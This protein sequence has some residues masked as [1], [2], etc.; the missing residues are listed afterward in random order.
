MSP[1]STPWADRIELPDP[2]PTTPV[3]PTPRSRGEHSRVPRLRLVPATAPERMCPRPLGYSNAGRPELIGLD[4]AGS[5]QHVHIPGATGT[6]K[7][8]L[9]CHLQIADAHA[10]R[11]FACL[12]PKGDLVRD[13][14]DRLP[15]SAAGRLVLIDPDTRSDGW[16]R[17]GG[18]GEGGV[19]LPSINVLDPAGRD[20]EL[21][22][23]HVVGVM[24]RVWAAWW[25]P[26]TDDIARHAVHA[27][28]HY[29]G[30][31][32][33]DVPDL[34][35][36]TTYRRHIL[37]TVRHKFACTPSVFGFWQWYDTL[38]AAQRSVVC[39]PLL[40][41]LRAVL[42][43]RVAAAL[44]GTPASTF[45]FAD[46][47]DGGILLARLPK[48]TLGEDTTRLVGALLLA[49]LW[50]AATARADRP[51]SQRPDASVH[52]DE[53]QNFLH[54]PIGLDDA[55]A[56]ARGMHVS[57]VLAHQHL[58]QL[59]KPMFAAIDA[60]ARNKIYFVASP[61]DATTLVRHLAPYFTAEDVAHV[62]GFEVICR[63][64]YDGA[65]QPPFT[66][67]T[68]PPTPVIAGRATRLRRAAAQRALTPQQREALAQR[69]HTMRARH[70]GHVPDSGHTGG[71]SA[72]TVVTLAKH[73]PSPW[74]TEPL[75]D[76][77]SNSVSD[78]V[79]DS[80]SDPLSE[81]PSAESDTEPDSPAGVKLHASGAAP[82]SPSGP[83]WLS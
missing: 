42:S 31:T 52:L 18:G 62:G 76:T 1:H 39:G 10:G 45:S 78:S 27:L 41:K 30:A 73:A 77:P 24:S 26:R 54:L 3:A 74:L 38:S 9:M 17:D 75:P 69:R 8:T 13:V 11:G 48:G 14:L 50:Q 71:H 40:S 4:I 67:D 35:A 22:V 65:I 20:P 16:G 32:L 51:E 47:L 43:R 70:R 79:S 36:D 63:L 80:L 28:A 21:V 56:E 57:F 7:S 19:V 59:P 34:L 33:A 68:L 64:V 15:T 61:Q 37:D 23:E 25:G 58:G 46:I 66:L 81:S 6:G 60:N 55:L 83:G 5:R 29:P 44:F 2:A 49:G 72:G 12:D 53:C 82:W